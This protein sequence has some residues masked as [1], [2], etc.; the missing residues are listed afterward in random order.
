MLQIKISIRTLPK[1]TDK[2]KV[3]LIEI[4]HSK[5]TKNIS[6]EHYGQRKT[7]P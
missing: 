3:Y 7:K 2:H 4:Y 1:I 5:Y 6:G